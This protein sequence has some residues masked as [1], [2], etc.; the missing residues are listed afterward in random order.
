M[1]GVEF[2]LFPTHEAQSIYR[3]LYIY[4]ENDTLSCNLLN[5]ALHT[6]RNQFLRSTLN[7][8]ATMHTNCLL[9]ECTSTHTK[10][11]KCKKT[12]HKIIHQI[13]ILIL[14]ITFAAIELIL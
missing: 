12:I 5:R 1:N 4:S 6:K 3:A 13:A 10:K 7:E 11:S 2:C 9:L 8:N 14:E